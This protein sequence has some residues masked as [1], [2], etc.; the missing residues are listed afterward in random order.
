MYLFK[1]LIIYLLENPIL[2]KSKQSF[3]FLRN[4]SKLIMNRH[5]II[6]WS[7]DIDSSILEV[8]TTLTFKNSV[9]V[10]LIM[11]EV[12]L[13]ELRDM[14]LINIIRLNDDDEGLVKLLT[15]FSF[16]SICNQTSFCESLALTNLVRVL[17]RTRNEDLQ[18]AF[19]NQIFIL[20]LLKF[21][22]VNEDSQKEV[23]R[24]LN[25]Q[26]MITFLFPNLKNKLLSLPCFSSNTLSSKEKM[27]AEIPTIEQTKSVEV[28]LK[29]FNTDAYNDIKKKIELTCQ[30][31]LLEMQ[32]S[33]RVNKSKALE[34]LYSN[35]SKVQESMKEYEESLKKEKNT[36]LVDALN[37]AINYG[38]KNKKKLDAFK[39]YLSKESLNKYS[40]N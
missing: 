24:L 34:K 32:K 9:D 33:A 40:F 31:S 2:P 22:L 17:A 10:R 11:K 1:S 20:K 3:N 16:E 29:V 30:A 28:F 7:P 5:T 26:Q 19:F 18:V 27:E 15:K 39:E 14:M 6:S 36:I 38:Q 4:L 21:E 12:K 35:K 37:E 13:F 8:I 23:A 25:D